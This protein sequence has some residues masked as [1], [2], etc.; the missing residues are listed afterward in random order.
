[1]IHQVRNGISSH[2]QFHRT[3]AVKPST[4][5]SSNR[6]TV[7][8]RNATGSAVPGS[9]V[10]EDHLSKEFQFLPG[11]PLPTYYFQKS[12][13]R[14]PIPKLNLTCQR[15]IEALRPLLTPEQL[16]KTEKYV[17]AFQKGA[18]I[19]LHGELVLKDKGLQH[20]SYISEPW[21][22][23]YL[24]D[25]QPLPINTNPALV[26]VED[27][28]VMKNQPKP[29]RQLVRST[30]LLVSALRFLKSLDNEILEPE[31]FHLSPGKTDTMSYR[32][33]MNM[34]PTAFATYASYLYKAFP[35]DMSQYP[36]LFR[37]SRIPKPGIDQL[38][39]GDKDV[40]HIAVMRNGNVYSVEVL[41]SD[42]NILPISVLM[43]SLEFILN[44]QTPPAKDPIGV[45]TTENRNKWADVREHLVTSSLRNQ[46]SLAM[47]DTALFV[48]SLDEEELGEADPLRVTRQY[49]HSDGTNRWFDKSFNIIVTKDGWAGMN[50]EHAWGDGVAVMRFFNDIHK[51]SLVNKWSNEVTPKRALLNPIRLVFEIDEKGSKGIS[52]ASKRY[53]AQISELQISPFLLERFGKKA[54][55]SWGISP[56]S[57]MQLGFQVAYHR[58]TSKTVT[59]YESCSTSAFRH[60]RTEAIRPATALT[61]EVSMLLSKPDWENNKGQLKEL[62]KKCS[63]KHGQLTKDAAMGQG[64]DRHLF[65][66]KKIALTANAYLP[67]IFKDESYAL[68]NYNI[69]STSTLSSPAV[70]V[71]AFG[72]VVKDG[73]GIAYQIWDTG[74][75]CIATTY[76]GRADGDAFAEE[77]TK[78]FSDIECA[79]T[80]K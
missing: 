6:F 10:E 24:K 29:R 70:R 57:L 80:S 12:L 30:N 42:G 3:V 54:C 59:T 1:M 22:E 48:L 19:A 55:K 64:F 7:Q 69:L 53:K 18:G 45:M 25:R 27:D 32:R 72:P 51:D 4:L 62:I 44:D 66:M 11:G 21:F 56:D 31:V 35:L 34:M 37:T 5:K 43:G 8:Y 52:D 15:Y 20:T 2:A 67:D 36:S 40:R 26:F 63:E 75:G 14:L 46:N 9:L 68:I 77:C 16:A 65:A 13:P 73:L 33:V 28:D 47:I 76:K 38:L 41:D 74:L 61:K 78:A 71:G 17:D 60:G 23:M 79:L 49:L 50:F 39:K 58:L